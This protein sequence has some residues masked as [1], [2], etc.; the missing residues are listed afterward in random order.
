MNGKREEALGYYRRSLAIQERE[1]PD[2]L[3]LAV[4]LY[5]IGEVHYQMNRSKEALN[6]FNR[7]LK[8]E[9]KEAPNSSDTTL[10]RDF[11]QLCQA[12][13]LC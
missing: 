13:G 9:E 4:T 1:M 8:I 3:S 5:N 2:S 12:R 10:T 11:I 6:C 7:A